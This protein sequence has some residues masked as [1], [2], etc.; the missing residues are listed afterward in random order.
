M[1]EKQVLIITAVVMALVIIGGGAAV[2]WLQFN[3][4]AG[5]RKQVA[6]L[7]KKVED[8]QDKASK[9]PGLKKE[10]D[11]IEKEI[12]EKQKRIPNL[13][14]MEYD[15]FAN[16]L[17]E[18]RS[19]A[20]VSVPTAKWVATGRQAATRGGGRSVPA[21]MHKVQYE[22]TVRGTFY[23]LLKY[24]NLLEEE[25][26]DSRFINV[27]SFTITSGGGGGEKEGQARH[28]R[29]MKLVLYSY[30]YRP[31]EKEP[32]PKA[33]AEAARTSTEVPE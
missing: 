14:R 32:P 25:S 21:T 5:K 13:D 26:K 9:I 22:M 33:V 19:R 4:L 29:D 6:E 17:D 24:V 20:G 11:R 8:A 2:W 31:K 15:R 18:K 10:T 3:V 16:L 1:S 7:T 28:V 12:A 23:Q 27:E 30:T